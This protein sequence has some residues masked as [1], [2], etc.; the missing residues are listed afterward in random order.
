MFDRRAIARVDDERVVHVALREE[1]Q[2]GAIVGN[3]RNV[4]PYIRGVTQVNGLG[5]ASAQA[6]LV[7]FGGALTA[8][9][10]DEVQ[11]AT[12]VGNALDPVVGSGGSAVTTAERGRVGA[13]RN[14]D[15]DNEVGG[16]PVDHD[17]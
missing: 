15:L 12:E 9:V 4:V 13:V 16:R 5:D 11:R 6:H 10:G 2:V 14:L 3:A 1:D 8:L 17:K 7:Q